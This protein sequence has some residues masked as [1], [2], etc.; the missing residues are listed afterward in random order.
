MNREEQNEKLRDSI[1]NLADLWDG[2]ESSR[3]GN[4]L[5]FILD[6]LGIDDIPKFYSNENI[7]QIVDELIRERKK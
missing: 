7:K 4:A 3:Y 2:Q 5:Q 1:V 6:E